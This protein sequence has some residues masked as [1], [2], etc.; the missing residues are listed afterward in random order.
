MSI[1][2]LMANNNWT[3][4]RVASIT[5]IDLDATN[6]I[7]DNIH[8]T[9][10]FTDGI[11]A[12]SIYTTNLISSGITSTSIYTTNLNSSGITTT[13]LNTTNLTSSGIT[14]TYVDV[15]GLSYMQ[16]I[17]AKQ[18]NLNTTVPSI[19]TTKISTPMSFSPYLLSMNEIKFGIVYNDFTIDDLV[20]NLD[21]ASNMHDI[22]SGLTRNQCIEFTIINRQAHEIKLFHSTGV[23]ING[24]ANDVTIPVNS[25]IKCILQYTALTED[26]PAYILWI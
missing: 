11:T 10:L 9:H 15:S 21:T 5:T 23:S 14:A 1:S 4:L 19:I 3:D 24:T 16:N 22:F 7:S 13:N 18:I 25:S 2:E 12:S 8:I 20:L 6:I 26:P 17:N